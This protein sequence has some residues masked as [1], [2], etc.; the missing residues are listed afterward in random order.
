MAQPLTIDQVAA[1]RASMTEEQLA[2]FGAS[3][4]SLRSASISVYQQCNLFLGFAPR[5]ER[6]LSTALHS[7]PKSLPTD[8]QR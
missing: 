3:V 4:M 6:P 8:P 1:L 5:D 7:L 2:A